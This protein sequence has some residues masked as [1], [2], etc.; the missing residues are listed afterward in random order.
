MTTA[1]A[2]QPPRPKIAA[3]ERGKSN[4]EHL[5]VAVKVKFMLRYKKG[6]AHASSGSPSNKK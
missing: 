4:K 5:I 3:M 2:E 6:G 1:E